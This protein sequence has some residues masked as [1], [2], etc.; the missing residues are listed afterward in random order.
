[1]KFKMFRI[2]T[3]AAA[4]LAVA[5]G[6]AQSTPI[7]TK[8]KVAHSHEEYDQL[9]ASGHEVV[10]DMSTYSSTKISPKVWTAAEL[11]EQETAKL[12]GGG[13]SD[14]C[15]CLK[16]IDKTY[17]IVPMEGYDA[18]EYRNDDAS[19][20]EIELPF[21]F[22]LYGTNYTS[23]YINNNGNVSFGSP[24][25]TFSSS[26]F[27]NTDFVMVAPFWADVDTRPA[28]SGLPWYKITDHYMIVIWD[29]VG[30]Y[31]QQT[32]K[33]NT[34]Q[35]IISDGTDPI[36]PNGNNVSFCYG[37]MEWTTGSASSGVGGFGGTPATVG[38][39]EGDGVSFMQAGRFDHAGSD[40]DGPTG[41]FDGVSW[42]DN[43]IIPINSCDATSGNLIPIAP[44]LTLCD[45]LYVCAGNDI[46]L[47][48]LG[49]EVDQ[50]LTI[51][52]TVSDE[53]T[54]LVF[55]P[56]V[57]TGAS[58][59]NIN[60]PAGTPD[61]MVDIQVTATDNGTPAQSVTLYY[62]IV[63]ISSAPPIEI[64]GVPVICSGQSTNLSIAAGYS[65]IAWNTGS[66]ASMISVFETGTY[67]V[68]AN[69]G[70]CETSGSIEVVA[71]DIVVPTISGE[72]LICSNATTTLTVTPSYVAY[73]WSDNSSTPTITVG[74]GTYSVTATDE[75][76]CASSDSFTINA[77]PAVT[78]GPDDLICNG[79]TADLTGSDRPG[80][81]TFSS[82]DGTA[83]F[84]D[85]TQTDTE[86][87]VSGYG[88]YTFDFH[89]T[90]CDAHDQTVLTFLPSPDFYFPT[91]TFA[92]LQGSL[93][94]Y[95]DGANASYFNWYWED[96]DVENQGVVYNVTSL[97]STFQWSATN[98]CGTDQG[99]VHVLA[100]LC[101]IFIPNVFTPD[102]DDFNQSFEI[103]GIENFDGSTL[104]VFNRWGKMVFE[105]SNY[106]NNW[107]PSE[108][109]AADGVYYYVL[110][111]NR[112]S[113]TEYF[114]GHVTLIRNP[115]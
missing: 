87:T 112:N 109:E 78:V 12:L 39:N 66:A 91:D 43:Q 8:V 108:D 11:E 3:V 74:P 25:G 97:D 17:S 37:D 86:V 89:D 96:I 61:T 114:S 54:G 63:V 100:E 82:D 77:I 99:T 16:A 105:S 94:L 41:A 7:E 69:L 45:T 103:V 35:L 60:A 34:F 1:M 14:D 110:G 92:C 19:S 53:T 95:P 10:M 115:K 49:P 51:N 18:P 101:E 48:F 73:D 93:Y 26:G 31:S 38:V 80:A 64:L 104:Q 22:C 44:V 2:L 102:G 21:T 68:T 33:L 47:Q 106:S 5:N 42:L 88:V 58:Q 57:N 23:C 71:F 76:G 50:T 24:Y 32:D 55:T 113:G 36:I 46:D 29:H 62:T 85:A 65:N 52:Y 4:L 107:N 83:T 67:S 30:Y 79:F 9:K 84:E 90:E 28:E 75:N 59:L 56:I 6:F 72:T 98:A 13:N 40:Y 70:G 27:P 111:L 15:N 81:W 20:P